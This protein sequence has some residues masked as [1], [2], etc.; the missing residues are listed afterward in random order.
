MCIKFSCHWS[1]WSLPHLSSGWPSSRSNQVCQQ[2]VAQIQCRVAG[3]HPRGLSRLTGRWSGPTAPLAASGRSHCTCATAESTVCWCSW[4]MDW[5]A[6]RRGL[7]SC[8]RTL[9]RLGIA[10]CSLC[11]LSGM[12][13]T[14]VSWCLRTGCRADR[15]WNRWT[16]FQ[17][18]ESHQNS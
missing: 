11:R 16:R 7:P 17:S 2:R 1:A 8:G 12:L 18:C 5:V 6:S 9:P 13:C 4:G 10:A 15:T 3:V 14:E